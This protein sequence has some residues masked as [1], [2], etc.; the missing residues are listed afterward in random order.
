MISK[1]TARPA[2]LDYRMNLVN[3]FGGKL[4]AIDP[5]LIAADCLLT[6]PSEERKPYQVAE[7]IAIIEICGDL[8]ND[9]CWWDETGYQDIRAEVSMALA[10][11]SVR[12]ILLRCNSPGGGV[13]GLPELVD[14]LADAAKQKPLWGMADTMAYSACL[15]LLSQCERIFVR[16]DSGGV[17]SIG[18]NFMHVDMSGA[19]GQA[20]YKITFISEG[21]GK[22]DANGMEPL[23]PGATKRITA[24]IKRFYGLFV[25][26]VAR[27]RKMSEA[28]VR[29]LEAFLYDGQESAISSG[30]ADY[31]VRFFDDAWIAMATMLA[32]K[33]NNG[34]PSAKAE[35]PKGAGNMSEELKPAVAAVDVE[36]IRKAALSEGF[37]QATALTGQIMNLCALAGK[38]ALAKGFMDRPGITVEAVTKELLEAKAKA[39]DENS[40]D[41]RSLATDGAEAPGFAGSAAG[42]PAN[43]SLA[44]AMEDE[45]KAKGG[46]PL[47]RVC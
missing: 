27:G 38:P 33:P 10:D 6:F 40:I 22:T 28:E 20:G 17:G 7:G 43:F 32:A 16:P 23:S 26:A 45:I 2:G 12:G 31:A 34:L 4:V 29:K 37:A 30:L 41:G 14:F 25:A 21:E 46:V 8:S 19:L 47:R 42:V 3:R 36:A 35:Q 18:V 44:G 11:P 5:R 24:E 39:T 13:D 9:P 1:R 15:A